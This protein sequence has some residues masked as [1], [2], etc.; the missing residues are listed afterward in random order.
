MKDVDN[1]VLLTVSDVIEYQFCPRFIYFMHCLDIP[2]HAENKSKVVKGKEVHEERKLRNRDYVRKKLHCIQKDSEV[3]LVSKKHH[4]KGIVDEVLF[5]EDGTAAPL[6]YK[7]AEDKGEIFSTYRYQLALQALLIRENYDR[8]VEKGYICYT[9][10]NYQVKEVDI[11]SS[12]TKKATEAIKEIL[13]IIKQGTYP[14]A[15]HDDRCT[16]CCYRNICV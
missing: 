13:T 16:D 8:K 11:T 15:T 4:V 1:E 7:F 14:D 5:L 2:Q 9:R 10:S 3:L 12:D 6:E